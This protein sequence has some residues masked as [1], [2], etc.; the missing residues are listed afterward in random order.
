[1]I[2]LFPESIR[3]VLPEKFNN[4]FRYTPH[5]LVKQAAQNVIETIS[6]SEKLSDLFAEGKMIGVLV[7]EKEGET[8]YLTAFSG[9][10]DGR[11]QIEGFV[12]PIFDL[13]EP[14]G[15]FRQKEA[16]ISEINRQIKELEISTEFNDLRQELI[17]AEQKQKDEINEYK[18]LMLIHKRERDEIRCEVSDPGTIRKLI[19]ESQFEKAELRRIKAR[20]E[21]HI[22]FLRKKLEET[23]SSIRRLQH[24]R[25][26]MSDKLQRWIFNQ[27]VV[28]NNLGDKAS[29]YEIFADKG[30]VP[31]GGTGECAAPKLLEYAYRN[32]LK[33][34]AMGEF[35]YGASPE[36][37]VRNSGMFYPSCTSKC[38]PL[39]EFM[40]KGLEI[41]EEPV[42][43][44]DYHEISGSP[45]IIW[46]DKHLIIIDKPS[47]MPSVPGNDGR[48]SLLEWLFDKYEQ[49]DIQ[50]IHRLDMD[51][52]G[53]IMFAKDEP[54]AIDMRRQFEAHTIHK[55]YTARLIPR[56]EGK[57]LQI[58]DK[59]IITLPISP[60]YDERPRQKVDRSQG[61]EA[62]TEY[63][64]TG[65]NVDGT[66][67]ILFRPHTGRTH[68]LR[69]HSAH[70]SGL[71][72]PIL[73]DTLYGGTSGD[74]SRLHLHS[75]KI[76]FTH[77]ATGQK[78][79]LSSDANRY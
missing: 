47:G 70:K 22:D 44:E 15:V 7:V 33:P 67:E 23:I 73:G 17:E 1:M 49:T 58:G 61:K 43:M 2:H 59:G 48:R 27:Y 75:H 31:P 72:H 50:S 60:D 45:E 53:I 79:S 10:L 42:Y 20:W 52:S 57:H 46:E 14:S 12:P 71:G 28:H 63:E 41:M 11:S 9:T 54:T 65:I 13:T 18:A 76:E 4:P 64:V 25:A 26:M 32:R 21:K 62:F 68:Q 8:G 30:L 78:I 51:T 74:V 6:H 19:N 38:G 29:I 69:V 34:I 66:I 56:K 39:L 55:E 5:E 24:E 35:W 16:E 37:A 77:P 36:S 3:S 40:L